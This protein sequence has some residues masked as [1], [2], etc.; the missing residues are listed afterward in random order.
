MPLIVMLEDHMGNISRQVRMDEKSVIANLIPAIIT[1]LKLPMVDIAGRPMVYHLTHNG[2]RLQ[3]AETLATADVQQG[4]TLTIVPEMRFSAETLESAGIQQENKFT[5]AADTSTKKELP[6]KSE[7]KT[8]GPEAEEADKSQPII[9]IFI[10]YSHT[11]EALWKG[12]EKQLIALKRQGLVE[13][14][15][16]R[17]IRPGTEWESEIDSHLNSAHIILLLISAS[18]LASDYCYGIEMKRALERHAKKEACVIPVILSPVY[19][20]ETPFGK[21]QALP[22]NAR[23]V[24]SW[25]RREEAFFDVAEG[26]RAAIK[27]LPL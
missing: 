21:L 6:G 12:L 9:E 5:P 1:N 8:G 4:D 11:D 26:I 14:W 23:P 22:Q 15:H 10:S 16:D 19:W 13:V 25:R 3:E 27:G 7:Q 18:F 17:A 2:R 20:H 24:T